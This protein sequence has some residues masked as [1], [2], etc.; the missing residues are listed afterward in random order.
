MHYTVSVLYRFLRGGLVGVPLVHLCGSASR[1]HLPMAGGNSRAREGSLHVLLHKLE[2][3][4]SGVENGQHLDSIDATD[5][6]CIE[7]QPQAELFD[8]VCDSM[9]RD[10]FCLQN[11]DFNSTCY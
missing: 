10:M 2:S 7:S 8:L 4:N 3:A 9:L 11:S 5:K 6:L 1:T